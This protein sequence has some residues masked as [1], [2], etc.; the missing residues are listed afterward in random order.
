VI[1][2]RKAVSDDALAVWNVAKDRSKKR[3]MQDGLSEGDLAREGFLLYPLEPDSPDQPNY[4]ERIELSSHFWVATNDDRVVGF[5][6]AYTFEELGS[7]HHHNANDRK[8]LE[9]FKAWGCELNCVYVA[10]FARVRSSDGKGAM[11]RMSER[12][13]AHAAESGAPAMICE[14]SLKPPN[15]ASIT[16]A[17]RNGFRRVATRIKDDP[18]TGLNRVSGTFMQTLSTIH[19]T[20]KPPSSE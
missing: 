13:R 10:Q 5:Y 15:E 14:I 1:E 2:V 6:M 9:Y 20:Q 11:D 16:A 7:F 3:R 19:S 17:L 4:R 12:C 8:V 18:T